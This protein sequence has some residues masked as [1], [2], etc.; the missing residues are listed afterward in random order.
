MDEETLTLLTDLHINNH[1]QGPGS[2][3]TLKRALDLSGIDTEAKI[4]IADIGC[5]TGSATIPLLK[6][7]NATIT[8]VD[9]LPAFLEKLQRNAEL[10]AVANRLQTVEAD[11]A[12]LP[13]TDERFDAIWSE[14]AMYNIG[15]E[16]SIQKWKKFLKP[17]GVLVASE[18]TWLRSDI[19]EEI[20]TYWEQEYPEIGTA[21][22][23][24]TVLEENGY[25]P[26]GYFTL[27][28]DC[29]LKEYY[30]PLQADLSTF[31]ERNNSSAKA[32][33]I[34]ETEKEE[35]E[36]YKKYQNYYSYG[37]Y[38]ARKIS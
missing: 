27:S 35:Y 17:S 4:T 9:L 3:H 20:K 13:F 15:F 8:A 28:S 7:T 31:L 33:E 30:E 25:S 26:I 29:W 14:G 10:E 34:I 1:R 5:G 23:K 24:L 19:P 2:F 6:H 21:S 22:N 37:V 11:M 32:Q 18:I 12:E 16:N 38:I 36:L